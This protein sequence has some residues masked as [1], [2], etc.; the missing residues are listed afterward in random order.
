MTNERDYVRVEAVNK[1]YAEEW[2]AEPEGAEK[3]RV[4]VGDDGGFDSCF[5]INFTDIGHVIIRR[6]L[7]RPP[8]VMH[9]EPWWIWEAAI[10]SK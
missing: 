9:L 6:E 1:G 8:G 4:R 10:S 5:S 3:R 2:G 7:W